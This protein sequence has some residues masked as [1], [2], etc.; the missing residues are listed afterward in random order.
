MNSLKNLRVNI[1][2]SPIEVLVEAYIHTLDKN[3]CCKTITLHISLSELEK[4]LN[5][6]DT[7]VCFLKIPAA[8]L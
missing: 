7:Y 5:G 4:K 3:V 2:M 6:H 1:S 8:L